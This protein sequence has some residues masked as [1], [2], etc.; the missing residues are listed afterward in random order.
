MMFLVAIAIAL[1]SA[2]GPW[3]TPFGSQGAWGV[4]VS[5]D[6]AARTPRGWHT[7]IDLVTPCGTPLVAVA[8]GEVVALGRDSLTLRHGEI[9]SRYDHLS[10]VEVRRG[11]VARGQRIGLSGRHGDADGCHLHLALRLGLAPEVG[12]TGEHPLELGYL[13]PASVLG[14][15]LPHR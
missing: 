6:F 1:A 15:A 13:S 5:R 12:Y 14:I 9:Y 11:S 4:A 2:P 8:A 7:G 3:T 10:L